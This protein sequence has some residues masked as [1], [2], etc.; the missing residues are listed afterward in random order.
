MFTND[1]ISC[2]D[3]ISSLGDRIFA[4][5]NFPFVIDKDLHWEVNCHI[6]EFENIYDKNNFFTY[7]RDCY[8][9]GFSGRS[10]DD[11][12]LLGSPRE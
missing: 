5:E 10:C 9:L 3:M 7:V 2:R 11:R 8:V 4:Q 12:L 1:V 6:Q